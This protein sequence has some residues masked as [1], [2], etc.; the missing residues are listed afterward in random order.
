MSSSPLALR[1]G[2]RGLGD[3]G[4]DDASE[5]IR[6]T[7]KEIKNVVRE[8]Q[9]KRSAFFEPFILKEDACP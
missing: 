2:S 9:Y 8:G 4:N 5:T 6:R 7:T 3:E 1:E